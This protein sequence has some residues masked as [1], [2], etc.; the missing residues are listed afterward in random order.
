MKNLIQIAVV[1]KTNGI[2][3]DLKIR[4]DTDFPE[5]FK[6]GESFL[7]GDDT[8]EVASFNAERTLIKFVGYDTKEIAQTLT[9]RPIYT[10]LEDTKK[11]CKLKKDEHFWFDMI[12]AKVVEGELL[13]GEIDDI[14]R[15]GGSD[16]LYITTD[17]HLSGMPKSFL[18]PYL[19]RYILNFE[20]ND[21]I[22][23]V[24]HAKDILEAS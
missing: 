17:E 16:Y 6:K 20:K 11:S 24:Q 10:T 5:Q 18:L 7:V 12:G 1:G 22:L 14:E 3:G 19:E 21:K 15:L 9:N 4:L 2:R 13:L 8:L 23:Y